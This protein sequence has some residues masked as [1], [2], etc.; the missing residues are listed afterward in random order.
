[1]C[2]AFCTRIDAFLTSFRSFTEMRR[3]PGLGYSRNTELV[4]IN[5]GYGLFGLVTAARFP[6]SADKSVSY[7]RFK[8]LNEFV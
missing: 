2:M 5:S 8:R 4:I 7:K 6:P 1:M 3:D